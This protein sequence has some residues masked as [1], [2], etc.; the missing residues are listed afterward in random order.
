M[1]NYVSLFTTFNSTISTSVKLPNGGLVS[2]THIGTLRISKHFILT[3]VLCVPSFPFI[4]IF[5]TKSIQHLNSYLIFINSYCFIQNL[6][7]WKTSGVGEEKRGLFHLIQLASQ[8]FAKLGV[9]SA[10]LKNP[11]TDL[12]H[13]RRGHL[14]NFRMSLLYNLVPFISVVSNKVCNICP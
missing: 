11:S 5:A 2:V 1:I 3:N 10:T 6:T 13:F 7:N 14:S 12:W 8:L 4:L 9:N